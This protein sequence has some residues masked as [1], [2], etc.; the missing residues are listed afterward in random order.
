MSVVF[1]T[2]IAVIL[3]QDLATWQKLNVTAFTISGI[4]ASADD[5]TGEPYGDG[6]GNIY[7]PMFRQPVPSRAARSGVRPK[8]TPD[9]ARRL[10]TL[11]PDEGEQFRVHPVLK[12]VSPVRRPKSPRNL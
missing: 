1:D 11:S 8:H 10:G 3:R 6:S 4:A 2:K 12:T 7:L 5:V 9:P